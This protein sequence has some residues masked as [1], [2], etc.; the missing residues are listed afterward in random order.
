MYNG[1]TVWLDRKKRRFDELRGGVVDFVW[2][3]TNEFKFLLKPAQIVA[4]PEDQ[5]RQ[6]IDRFC[7]LAMHSHWVAPQSSEETLLADYRAITLFNNQSYLV[8]HDNTLVG[9]R[10]HTGGGSQAPGKRIILHYQ[11]HFWSV[12]TTAAP[13]TAR[14]NNEKIIQRAAFQ[15]L[16]TG[17]KIS[18]DRYIRELRYAGVGVT[19]HFHPNFAMAIIQ[20]LAPNTKSWFDPSMGWGGR[21]L[22]AHIL[23]V[24]YEGCDPQSDTF[25]GLAQISLFVKSSAV[26]HCLKAQCY[27]FTKRFD[28]GFTSPPFFNKERYGGSEQSYEEFTTYDKWATGF[29]GPLV[30]ALLKNCDRVILHIDE[31]MKD[32]LCKWYKVDIYPVSLQRNPGGPRGHEFVLN[33]TSGS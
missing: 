33:F 26:L 10:S 29:L 4:L 17:T 28:L 2:P 30:D 21:L 15:L 25:R 18:L 5:R 6:I 19:S 8:H 24:Q 14:W 12:K 27:Q 3:R 11:P 31:R 16:T 23:D 32:T 1:A 22:A 7:Y 13:I 9:F 20:S